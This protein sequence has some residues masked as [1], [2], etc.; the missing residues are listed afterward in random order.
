M[1][2]VN[3]ASAVVTAPEERKLGGLQS[4]YYRENKNTTLVR[5]ELAASGSDSES[6]TDGRPTHGHRA[7]G[8]SAATVTA[9]LARRWTLGAVTPGRGAAPPLRCA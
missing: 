8:P 4:A 3:S 5:V 1:T 2:S 9:V 6:P 7:L